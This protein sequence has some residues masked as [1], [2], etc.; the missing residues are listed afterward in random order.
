MKQSSGL[1]VAGGVLLFLAA[2]AG[3]GLALHLECRRR[4][5]VLDRIVD[6]WRQDAW[7]VSESLDRERRS[8]LARLW[9]PYRRRVQAA[10]LEVFLEEA[11]E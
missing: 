8:S 11:R 10:R 3:A 2:L 6:A 5:A 7:D 9:P 1:T 4:A